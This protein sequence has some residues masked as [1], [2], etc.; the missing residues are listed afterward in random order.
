MANQ[1]VNKPHIVRIVASEARRKYFSYRHASRPRPR[2][3]EDE[4]GV[5]FEDGCFIP[6]AD[7]GYHADVGFYRLS[8]ATDVPNEAAPYA[9]AGQLIDCGHIVVTPGI[10]QRLTNDEIR[11]LLAR[12]AAGDFGDYGEFYDL[13]VTDDMLR[14][15]PVRS[16]SP[17][18]RSKV[19]ALT[20]LNPVASAYTV[21]EH[22]V[23]VITEAGAKPTTI[24]LYAGPALDE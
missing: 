18:L 5:E 19:S 16:L 12:H 14:N 9:A 2:V 7:L 6:Y 22:H 1:P 17:G 21:R 8:T 20:G 10:S 15:G 4:I 13:D 11:D 3:L 24:L 23:W